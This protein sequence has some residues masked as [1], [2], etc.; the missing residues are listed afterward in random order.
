MFYE[1]TE[2]RLLISTQNLN[3]FD[4]NESFWQQLVAD[5][6]AEILS[7]IENS[8]VKAYLL[9][10]SSLFIWKHTLLLITCGNT[11][12]V[13]AALFVQQQL[14]K[15]QIK[16]LIFQRHQA[17][18]PLLQVSSFE[19]DTCLLKDQFNGQQQHWRGSYQG[20][21]FIFGQVCSSKLTNHS[22][23]MLHGLHGRF[24]EELQTQGL[25][26]H[27]ILAKL[28]L[29]RFFSNLLVDHFS[30][31]PKGYSLNAISDKHYITLHLTPELLSTYLSVESSFPDSLIC[32]FIKHLQH[33]F[34]PL[35]TKQMHFKIQ[36]K[37]LTI[38][39]D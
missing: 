14:T 11:Q 12:L 34:S 15:A 37:G 4:L 21:L 36:N 25:N 19:Q 20:D 32:G 39:A 1:G 8:N 18:K 13:K 22:I 31:S 27:S 28:Q 24:S 30:F 26:K 16:T 2:K 29:H 17:L 33:L 23:Y 35:Q 5:A 6:D 3:L 9:S 10:E 7:S 38:K